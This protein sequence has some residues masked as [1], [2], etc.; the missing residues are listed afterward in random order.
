MGSVFKKSYT[1]ALPPNAEIITRKGERFARWKDQKGKTQTKPLTIGAD[2]SERIVHESPFFVAKYRDGGNVVRTVSTGCRDETAA[3]QVL[4]DLER[5]AELV[6]SGI[7]TTAEAAI[8]THHNTPFDDHVE[9]YLAYLEA[10]GTCPEHRS[11]RKRQ[12]C[13]LAN[14]LSISTLADLHRESLERWLNGQTRNGMG[15]RTRN[16]YHGSALAFANW[17]VETSRLVLNPFNAVP[18]ANEKADQ[19]RQRRAMT[20]DELVRLLAVARDR[21]LLEAL[22][23]RKG[24]RKGEPCADVRPEVR[25][26]LNCLGRERAAHLQD[27][28]IDRAAQRGAFLFN[29][30]TTLS[31]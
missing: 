24:P 20:D 4:A 31:R 28:T 21:P 12:L 15:A 10:K 16:S 11:E 2:G 25:E 18:K 8:G 13:R 17:C 22:T 23:V 19:R 7:M 29:R 27:A 26:R 30:G 3:R 5:R 6:R 14:E 9:A 1:K